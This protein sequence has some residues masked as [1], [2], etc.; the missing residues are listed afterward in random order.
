MSTMKVVSVGAILCLLLLAGSVFA[1]QAKAVNPNA[2]AVAP[3]QSAGPAGGST[4][5]I[6]A[7]PPVRQ[8]RTP[9]LVTT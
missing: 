7:P 3:S 9:L 4:D 6:E 1:D 5:A 8:L 2:D